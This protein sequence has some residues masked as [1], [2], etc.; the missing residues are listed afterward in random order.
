MQLAFFRRHRRLFMILMFLGVIGF[1]F[2]GSWQYIRLAFVRLFGMGRGH[3]TIGY[4][5]GEATTRREVAEFFQQVQ[6]GGRAT[7]W[8]LMR[9]SRS[10]TTQE[11][12]ADAYRYTAGMS[13]WPFLSPSMKEERPA[14]V[15]V[16]T[17]LAL[18]KEAQQWGFGTS[19]AEVKARIE[20]LRELGLTSAE[21]SRV[22]SNVAGGEPLRFYEALRTDMTLRAYVDWL[23]EA[24]TIPVEPEMRR[25]FTRTDEQIKVRLIV[26]KAEDFV[27]AAEEP[28]PEALREQFEK[29]KEYLAGEGPKG[30]GYRTAASVAIEYLVADPKAFEE[31]TRAAV[32][33]QM[34]E[35]YYEAHKDSEFVVKDAPEKEGEDKG[36]DSEK[37]PDDEEGDAEE[38]A[39]AEETFR[40]LEEVREEIRD[41]LV[42]REAERLAREKMEGNVAQI[43]S[44]KKPP[45]LQI[46][47]DETQVRRAAL[48]E[49]HTAQQLAALPGLGEATRGQD[50]LPQCAL[51]LVGLVA[52]E[53]ARLAPEEISE[54]FV[55]PE[56]RAYAFRVTAYEESRPPEVLEEV[57]EQVA[58]DLRLEAAFDLVRE[59]GRT[60][61][62]AA[63]R[64]GLKAAAEAEGVKPEET[65][66]FPR[67][68]GP[69]AYMGRYIWF[70]PALPGIGYNQLVTDECFR[71]SLDPE[72]TRR[73]LVVLPRG[74]TVIVA[75]LADHRSPREAAYR[76]ERPALAMQ[77]G[78]ALAGK[79]RDKLLDEEAIRRRL[80]V[81]YSPPEAEREGPEEASGEPAEGPPGGSN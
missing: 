10:A 68:R 14:M 26:L 42:E 20:K 49:L 24:L 75:E 80:G 48:E 7:E 41:R 56:G 22:V 31:E 5:G 30:F 28:S 36:A 38:A 32:T 58:A 53:K 81:V 16:M 40:P 67:Q 12:A 1:V 78:V 39:E 65:D 17:W 13:A 55:D 35:E 8:C 21:L 25:Q 50:R 71:L 72:G 43:R 51:A 37:D 29:Y 52:P 46:W 4:I 3:Q 63:A 79:I 66:W 64:K 19:D 27:D 62:E 6:A 76:K 44:M 61:L 34:V 69:F 77:V 57:R 33:D 23:T 73:T 60:I 2:F 18:Y 15:S 74:R 45:D 54:V 47:A 11:D 70:P 9:L 59:R